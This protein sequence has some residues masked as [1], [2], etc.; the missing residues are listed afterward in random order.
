MFK[1][2]DSLYIDAIRGISGLPDRAFTLDEKESAW[3]E[4]VSEFAEAD[5]NVDRVVN[6]LLAWGVVAIIKHAELNHEG[7]LSDTLKSCENTLTYMRELV[8]YKAGIDINVLANLLKLSIE[9]PEE[10]FYSYVKACV[11]EV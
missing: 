2:M 6:F 8:C 7:M 10:V 9:L 11:G 1:G 4:V 5:N 3:Y